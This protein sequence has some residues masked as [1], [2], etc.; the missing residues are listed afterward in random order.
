MGVGFG[1]LFP[2]LATYLVNW[3]FDKLHRIGEYLYAHWQTVGTSWQFVGYVQQNIPFLWIIDTTP[4]ILGILAYLIGRKQD[5]LERLNA[6]QEVLIQQRTDELHQQNARLR[7]EITVRRRTEAALRQATQQAQHLAHSKDQFL[8]AMSH[9][10]RTPLHGI[11]GM[12]DLLQHETLSA[13]QH[14][15]L[16]ALRFS[17]S[18]LHQLVNDLLDYQKLEEDR[19]SIES[20]AFDLFEL[21]AQ[22]QTATAVLAQQK[23][24]VLRVNLAPKVPQWV[25]GD[26]LRLQQVL[27]NL[28]SNALKFTESGE[29]LLAIR[30]AADARPDSVGLLFEVKDTGIGIAPQK[31]AM[32]FDRF[33]QAD[34]DTTRRFG[35]TGL[36]LA[37]TRKLLALQGSRIQVDSEVGRGSRF[38]FVQHFAPAN[39]GT[40]PGK[41]PMLQTEHPTWPGMRVLVAE[42][43]RINQL[44]IQKLLTSC[45]IEVT[46]VDNGAQAVETVAS[47]ETFD[48]VLMD[49]HMHEMDGLEATRQIRRLQA[50]LDQPLPIVALT[51]AVTEEA[52]TQAE[53]AGMN[54]MLAKP[55]H[56]P[57]VYKVLETYA[58]APEEVTPPPGI[59]VRT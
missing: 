53:Q 19:L 15:Y 44:V 56:K 28:L 59:R 1:L 40:V 3:H 30:L 36:G 35:G 27:H 17:A 33:T 38:Y 57:L 47:Q 20:V 54:G 49:L 18:H 14:T 52:R 37:I 46:L 34:A 26:P 50:H 42:D 16:E 12:A 22:L 45:Q 43:D 41:Q 9:E 23:K 21:V 10:I 32:I 25:V 11:I 51:A 58:P 39:H 5:Q 7:R 55:M 48:L 29:I 31:L 6:R 8:S 13:Q 2:A 4:L 24:L